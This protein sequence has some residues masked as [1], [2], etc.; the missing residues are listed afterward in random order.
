MSST[1][2]RQSPQRLSLQRC[3][4][5]AQTAEQLAGLVAHQDNRAALLGLARR[6]RERADSLR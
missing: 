3:R 6:W 2:Q 4:K 5:G 1:S